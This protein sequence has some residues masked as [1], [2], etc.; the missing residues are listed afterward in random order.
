MAL[1]LS[2]AQNDKFINCYN[3]QHHLAGTSPYCISTY[4]DQKKVITK[5]ILR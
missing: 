1:S 2:D 3:Y 5:L 4:F